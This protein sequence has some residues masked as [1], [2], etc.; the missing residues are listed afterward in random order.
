MRPSFG[1]GARILGR[2]MGRI[3]Y[4]SRHGETDWNAE[5]RWQ[6]HTD[7]PLNDRGREQARA[8][9][10]TL[11][12]TGLSGIVTSDL[13]RARETGVIVA[14]ALGLAIDYVD[15]DLRERTI[16]V[17]EGLNREEC[18]RLHPEAWAAW[19]ERHVPP[20]GAEAQETLAE[21][22]TLAIGRAAE[23]FAGAGAPVLLVTH[24]GAMRAALNRAG[25][26]P[27]PVKNTGVWKL[28]WHGRI[29]RAEAF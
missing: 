6:G 18:E 2:P 13:Q 27:A 14:E 24:G 9:A 22:V 15:P 4:L 20:P 17:F 7:K 21:R 28:E 26:A 11:R 3:I 16:G 12:G 1:F 19:I 25:H 10:E 29:V 8:L 5:G 23:R